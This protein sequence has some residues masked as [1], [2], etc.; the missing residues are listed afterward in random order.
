MLGG[1]VGPLTS[2][3]TRSCARTGVAC[4]MARSRVIPL[5]AA[6]P[7]EW[8]ARCRGLSVRWFDPASN[9]LALCTYEAF[10]AGLTPV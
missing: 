2:S 6:A 3:R 9:V 10:V 5:V 1:A 4:A 7:T 8:D